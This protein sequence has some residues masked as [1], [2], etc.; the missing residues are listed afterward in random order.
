METHPPDAGFAGPYVPPPPPFPGPPVPYAQ[1]VAPGRPLYTVGAIT[2]ATFLGSPVAG[3]IVMAAN[4]R[5]MNK[6]GSAAWAVLLGILGTAAA[7]GLAMVLP[8]KTPN[9]LFWLPPILIVQAL[10]KSLQ[11]P[12]ID[13]Q[14]QAGVRPAS[15]W[16]AA[17]IGAIFLLLF[18]GAIAA[19]YFANDLRD[20]VNV[21][22]H[23][24]IYY[25]KGATRDDAVRLG[26]QLKTLG[27][28]DGGTRDKSVVLR[29]TPD[30]GTSVSFVV[31][32]FDSP[33][34]VT[35]FGEV[36][37]QLAAGGFPKPVTVLLCDEKLNVKR[38]IDAK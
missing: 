20:K 33:A 35:A 26:D 38:T 16:G 10:A 5:R 17:G 23:E 27:F 22:A 24:E 19:F 30:G 6:P 31:S 2:L 34:I 4:Y 1:T 15:A 12:A 8:E 3:G 9:V 11:G 21:S 36:A 28:F 7:F 13:A 32:D 18:G 29:R 14:R 25:A 37:R